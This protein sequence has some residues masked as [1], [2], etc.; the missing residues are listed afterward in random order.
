M[1]KFNQLNLLAIAIAFFSFTSVA[2]NPVND[3]DLEKF[4]VIY[5]QVQV[6]NENFQEGM[7]EKIEA[8]GMDVQRFNEIHNAQMNPQ[9]ETD[10]SESELQTHKEIVE[11]LEKEQT[12]FQ[13]KVSKIIVKEGLT[14]EKYQEIFAALQSD[15]NLQQKFNE[16]MQG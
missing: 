14:L 13:E 6:E 8:E 7:V 11:V 12:V 15:Q 10:A 9:V 5:K 3:Q 4:V 2:Q 1:F 16:M